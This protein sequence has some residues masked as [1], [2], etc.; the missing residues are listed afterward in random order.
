M[1]LARWPNEGFVGIEK[2]INPGSKAD[3]R[4][5]GVRIRLRS[6][7]TMDHSHRCLALR[8]LPFP[9]GRR[10]D[11]DRQDRSRNRN[12]H[13][14]RTL[15]L[16]RPR[17]EHHAGHPVLRLQPARRNRP[18]G[19]VVSR[20]RNRRAL[21]LPTIRST[22]VHRRDRHAHD[23]DDHHGAGVARSPGRARVRPGPIQRHRRHGLRATVRSS[24]VRS[25]AWRATAS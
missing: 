20:T 25:V 18:A 3:G 8:L 14:R 16:R 4:A 6:A 17:D 22:Q 19:R 7:R 5:V 24:A 15:S 2:L 12:P 23:A 9:L 21:P 11:Q 10:D 13:H 1:T